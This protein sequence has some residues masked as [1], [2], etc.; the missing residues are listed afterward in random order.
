MTG[1]KRGRPKSQAQLEQE[2]TDQW[3]RNPPSHII[4]MTDER[5]KE[6]EESFR[7]S[8]RVRQELLRDYKHGPTTPDNHAYE[9]ASLG[10]ESMMGHEV[11]ILENDKI[12]AERQSVYRVRGAESTKEKADDRAQLLV[13]KNR[14]L[15]GLISTTQTYTINKVAGLI[16]HQWEAMSPGNI[17]KGEPPGMDKRGIDGPRPSLKTIER[18][19][20]K[21]GK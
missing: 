10:D 9:M 1:R 2:L 16:A 6:L 7:Q 13:Q 15:I 19:I 18:W 20:K 3:L 21:T 8:E 11:R 12:F 4:P 5:T 14:V 17:L